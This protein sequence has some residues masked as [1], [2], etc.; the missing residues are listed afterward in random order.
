MAIIEA[1]ILIFPP[2]P[3]SPLFHLQTEYGAGKSRVPP[4]WDIIEH[5]GKTFLAERIE[6]LKEKLTKE[7]PNIVIT[8]GHAVQKNR[9]RYFHPL[10]P[11]AD[12]SIF[13]LNGEKC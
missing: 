2:S 5:V 12:P 1:K 13:P 7:L 10:E 9:F 3:T 8:V 11:G 4:G 6:D